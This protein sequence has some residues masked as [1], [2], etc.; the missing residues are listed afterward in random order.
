MISS[1]FQP[2]FVVHIFPPCDFANE[3][4]ARISPDLL[5]R[6]AEISY[7][8]VVIATCWVSFLI[9]KKDCDTWNIIFY[10][11]CTANMFYEVLEV[12]FYI[13]KRDLNQIWNWKW[14]LRNI[15]II[16]LKV[17]LYVIFLFASDHFLVLIEEY[18]KK[19]LILMSFMQWWNDHFL[20]NCCRIFIFVKCLSVKLKRQ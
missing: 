17:V 2:A 20:N 10:G 19:N 6:V 18:D 5:H 13:L 8:L 15:E 12:H 14:K 7:L 1:L 11:K 16:W 9:P 4:L 3:N